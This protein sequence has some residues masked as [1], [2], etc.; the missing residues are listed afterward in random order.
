MLI[1]DCYNVRK[2]YH[3][4]GNDIDKIPSILNPAACQAE[5]QKLQTCQYWTLNTISNECIRKGSKPSTPSDVPWAISGPKYC[6]K[7]KMIY[8]KYCKPT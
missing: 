2:D 4:G 3:P 5:C 6:Q 1:T 7:G 8:E